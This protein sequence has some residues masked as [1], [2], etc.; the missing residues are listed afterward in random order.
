MVEHVHS[1]LLIISQTCVWTCSCILTLLTC[2][3]S[4]LCWCIF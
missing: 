3:Y 4:N 2:L 1:I